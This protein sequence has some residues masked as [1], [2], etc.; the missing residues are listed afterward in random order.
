[1]EG[2]WVEGG[3][4]V[5]ENCGRRQSRLGEWGTA[6]DRERHL[7]GEALRQREGEQRM[8]AKESQEMGDGLRQRKAL[9]G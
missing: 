7:N 1:M 2:G 3:G 4:S 8:A 5:W 9:K 6:H